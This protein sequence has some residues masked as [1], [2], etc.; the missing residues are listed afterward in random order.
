ML[1]ISQIC[2]FFICIRD[3]VQWDE[4]QQQQ[5]EKKVKEN[6]EKVML[7]EDRLKLEDHADK[8]WDSFYNNHQ[9]RC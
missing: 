2:S 6:S 3:N 7:E 4:E 9:N 1:T 5:A 8:Y